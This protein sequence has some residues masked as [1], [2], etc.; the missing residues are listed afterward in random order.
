MPNIQVHAVVTAPNLVT[1]AAVKQMLAGAEAVYSS[2]DLTFKLVSFEQNFDLNLKTDKANVG[3]PPSSFELD[4]EAHAVRYPGRIVIYFR[5]S[6]GHGNYSSSLADYVVLGGTNANDFAHEVGHYLHLAHTFY[7]AKVSELYALN[8]DQGYAQAKAK[9][10]EWIKQGGGLDVFDG[11]S[12]TVK[13]TPPDPGPPLFQPSG[14]NA[15]GSAV[16]PTEHCSVMLTLTVDGK[17]YALAPDRQNIMSYFKDCA[18]S[19]HISLDQQAIVKAALASGNR[20]HL[21]D[22]VVPEGPAAVVT[23]DGRIHVF[24][25]G[26]D[27]NIWRTFWNGQAW[28]GWKADL[29]AGSLSSGPAAVATGSGHIHVFARGDDRN[30]WHSFWNG[31][32]WGGWKADLGAGTLTSDP[33]AVVT[34][35]GHIHVFARGDDRNIWHTFWNGQAW[36]GW[37]ANV[38]VGT[39]TSGTAAVRTAS[40]HIHLFARGDDRNVWH[41]FWDGQAW[42]GWKP[43]LGAGTL[44]SGPAAV[45]TESGHIHVFARGDDRKMWHTFWNGQAWSGWAANLAEG[46]FMTGL[47]PVVT[48]DG[49][50]HVFA[51]ADD[52]KVWHSFWKS[53][54]WSSW[55]PELG[56]GT[57]QT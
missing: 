3:P 17:P 53:Q 36:S 18:G 35:S 24:G 34:G 48:S 52:R 32:A 11:D 25:R 46:T 42:S 31:Q 37:K 8:R 12:G 1:E 21:V 50:L 54:S 16:N 51:Q 33:A 13:D 7:D 30:I 55:K 28:S 45:V 5:P 2:I 43:D 9:A 20:R 6:Q 27:S 57:F 40:G 19:H 49:A 47:A 29:G 41:T 4:R 15:D 39:L 26:D 14:Y 10:I 22:G 44:T 23:P 56:A 38:A